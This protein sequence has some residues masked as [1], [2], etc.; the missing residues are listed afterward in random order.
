MTHRAA[1]HGLFLLGLLLA[2]AACAPQLQPESPVVSRPA[3]GA[4]RLV[5]DDG[6]AL[7]LRQWLPRGEPTAVILALH[8]FNDYS[9]AFAGPAA[10][11][12]EHGIA[13]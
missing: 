6:A 3:I 10:Y 2:L 9:R 1:A 7:P 8:G 12:A 13:T 11:W 4:D 5:M